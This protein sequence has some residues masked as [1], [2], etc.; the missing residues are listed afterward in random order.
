MVLRNEHGAY[1]VA[2]DLNL[3]NIRTGRALKDSF[4]IKLRYNLCHT[5]ITQLK[6]Q[7]LENIVSHVAICHTL[8]MTDKIQNVY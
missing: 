6:A 1:G 2:L 7:N 3:R 4:L 8:T 5:P